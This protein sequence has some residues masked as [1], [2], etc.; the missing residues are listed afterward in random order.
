MKAA[1]YNISLRVPRCP[2]QATNM[3]I[4]YVIY[5]SCGYIKTNA[6]LQL[7]DIVEIDFLV[8]IERIRIFKNNTDLLKFCKVVNKMKDFGFLNNHDMLMIRV[9]A[10][11][12]IADMDDSSLDRIP[13]KYQYLYL[14]STQN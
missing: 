8:I 7:S 2:K 5:H 9:V 14:T 4:N 1:P 6:L 13:D 3:I 11:Q 12:T 10:N